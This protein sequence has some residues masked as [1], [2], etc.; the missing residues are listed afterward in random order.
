MPRILCFML[1]MAA[2]VAYARTV[3]EKKL[4]PWARDYKIINPWLYCEPKDECIDLPDIPPAWR[5]EPRLMDAPRGWRKFTPLGAI[6]KDWTDFFH[7]R[8]RIWYDYTEDLPD[9]RWN[10]NGWNVYNNSVDQW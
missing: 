2:F 9:W 8:K 5:F 3:P 4:S 1:V 10:Y 7:A 6:R